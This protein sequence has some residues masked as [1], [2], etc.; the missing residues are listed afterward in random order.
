MVNVDTEFLPDPNDLLG[1]RSIPSISFKDAKVG[2]YFNGV[3]TD[4]RTV[5]VRSYDSGEPEFW[6]DG[7]PKLQIEVT[8]ATEYLDPSLDEDDGTRRVYL[9]GQ[10]LSAAKQEMKSQGLSKLE[11][12]MKFT[13]SF[14]GE[15]PSSNK[16]YNN[17]KMY[18][19]GIEPAVSN[20]D[21]DALLVETTGA[22][23]VKKG[24]EGAK[25]TAA[26]IEK[27]KKLSGAGFV[28]EEIAEAMSVNKYLV[29][30]LLDS[31][32]F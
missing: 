28:A 2:D 30:E 20:P 21:V 18:G 16:K 23:P 29:E 25:L 17:V 13:I 9:F 6:D 4:L 7:K 10:K 24:A 31:D 15:K 3:I 8:L 27:A 22:K 19:I 1:T 5:Q 12:G 32:T 26:Q 14:V 11:K